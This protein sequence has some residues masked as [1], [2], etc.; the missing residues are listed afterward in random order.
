MIENLTFD[1]FAGNIITYVF[2]CCFFVFV[3]DQ[4]FLIKKIKKIS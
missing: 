3:F 4:L 1:L 2:S